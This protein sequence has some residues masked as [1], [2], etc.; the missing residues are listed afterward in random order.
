M[1]SDN[2]NHGPLH[3]IRVLEFSQIVA[4]PTAGVMLSDLGADVI[5]VEP[6]GGEQT[7]RTAAIVP[8][9]GKGFQALNRGKRSLIIDLQDPRGQ[10]VIQRIV[11]GFDVVLINYRLGVA[12]RIGIDYETLKKHRP[13][14]IYWQ[15]TGFGEGVLK[16]QG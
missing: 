7:R 14:L 12:E 4:A 6:H 10:A 1:T 8:F 9:E 11:T 5:K 15:N 3:G 13:D 2:G 16:F